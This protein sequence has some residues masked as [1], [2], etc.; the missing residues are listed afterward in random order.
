MTMDMQ[1]NQQIKVLLV[2]D[3]KIAQKVEI[4]ILQR[5]NC[6]VDVASNGEQALHYISQNYYN[7]IFMDIG[8]P[9]MD[10]LAVT[11]AIRAEDGKNKTVPIIALTAHSDDEYRNKATWVGMD[12][13]IVKP[14]TPEG[15]EQALKDFV[16]L[17][18]A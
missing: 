1:N 6:F 2:E 3:H 18:V 11:E 15:C 16:S 9:D 13:Y 17:A 5:L 8:L 7:I 12:A 10:G 4:G 14:L